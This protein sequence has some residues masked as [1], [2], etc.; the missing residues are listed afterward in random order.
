LET[1]NKLM[2]IEIDRNKWIN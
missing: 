2:L 1:A